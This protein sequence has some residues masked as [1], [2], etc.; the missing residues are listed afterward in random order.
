MAE[1][2]DLKSAISHQPSAMRFFKGAEPLPLI[3][4]LLT[5]G[6]CIRVF[7]EGKELIGQLWQM[8]YHPV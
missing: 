5:F 2:Q 4:Y 8:T 3:T 1:S 7:T 6:L